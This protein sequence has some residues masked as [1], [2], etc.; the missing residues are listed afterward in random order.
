MDD[1][2]SRCE[3]DAGLGARLLE[4]LI[5]IRSSFFLCGTELVPA[6]RID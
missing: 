6:K 5:S 3:N 4:L 2:T 1:P